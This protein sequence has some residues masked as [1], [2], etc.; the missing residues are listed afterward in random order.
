MLNFLKNESSFSD[1]Q[2]E[3]IVNKAIVK[4]KLW[5]RDPASAS[6]QLVHGSK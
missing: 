4:K 1:L 3:S 6:L 5:K 2:S